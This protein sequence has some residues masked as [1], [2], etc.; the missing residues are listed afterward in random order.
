[1]CSHSRAVLSLGYW[2]QLDFG[3]HSL[4]VS[5]MSVNTDI[6]DIMYVLT[7]SSWIMLIE[8]MLHLAVEGILIAYEVRCHRTPP[9]YNMLTDDGFQANWRT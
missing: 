9:L 6:D 5:R 4:V 2:A 7:S 3:V 1:M 8:A